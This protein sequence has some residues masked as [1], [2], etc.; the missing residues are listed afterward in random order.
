MA[1]E[2]TTVLTRIAAM[3]LVLFAGWIARRVGLIRED[4]TA[5]LGRFTVDIAFPALTLT[6]MLQL[7]RASDVRE[8]GAVFLLGVAILLVACGVGLAAA[9][10]CA[11]RE[12]RHTFAFLVGIPNW[13]FLP[14]PIAEALA[15]AAGVKA[16][17]LINIPAQVLL[18]TLGVSVLRGGLR[19]AHSVRALLGN[20]GLLA[21]AAGIALALL[22]PSSR[23]WHAQSSVP[24]AIVQGLVLLGGLTVP[25][26]LVVIGAQLGGL[27]TK[28]ATP[29][30]ELGGV[31]ALRLLAAPLVTILAV[32]VLLLRVV[33]LDA[34]S[35]LVGYVIASMPVAVSCGMFVERF[36]GDRD[37]AARAI[38][39]S[40][41]ASLVTV[42]LVIRLAG[43]VR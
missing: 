10:A 30:R 34:T 24:G 5:A 37:L 41:L 42:P 8:S 7:V 21:T 23:A 43:L 9:P 1:P 17:L 14:L 11:A 35:R 27:N 19:G 3:F 39:F 26:S 6:Q 4:T 18:W 36:G 22:V 33:D 40:T 25:L 28:V 38:L 32:E 29:W 12:H 15:G 2:W 20:P 13:I 31:L 16:V